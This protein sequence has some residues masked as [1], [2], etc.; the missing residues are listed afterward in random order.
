MRA[1][2]HVLIDDRTFVEVLGGV[3]RGGA[4]ELD[5][6]LMCLVVGLAADEG[7]E[8]RV[9]DVDE[10]L[11]E[12]PGERAPDDLHVAGENDE[13]D[14]P[15]GEQLQLAVLGLL[16]GRGC[17]RRDDELDAEL[18]GDGLEVGV[19]RHHQGDLAGE[20][21]ALV[22]EQQI[23]QTVIEL[24]DE[25]RD[26]LGPPRVQEP[27]VH[28]EPLCHLPD[29]ALERVPVGLQ[30]SQIDPDALEELT[31]LAV[32]VL[33]GV[34]DVA[35]VPVQQLGQPG[36]DARPVRTRDEEG[37]EFGVHVGLDASAC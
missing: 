36:D 14:L 31:S 9:V 33:V 10:P 8:E 23:V 27:R 1:A 30:L 15:L 29:S 3:V 26:P 24:R 18:G 19:V 34:D 35:A 12:G 20:L 28:V 17:L 2:D 25:D 16:P 13:I 21:P 32:G 4:D 7:R 22:A 11:L 6:S 5:A 37:R